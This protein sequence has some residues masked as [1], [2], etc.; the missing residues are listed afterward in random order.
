MLN[1]QAPPLIYKTCFKL[2]NIKNYLPKCAQGGFKGTLMH[3]N[4]LKFTFTSFLLHF[5]PHTHTHT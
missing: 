1:T 4:I 3:A 2:V 5:K